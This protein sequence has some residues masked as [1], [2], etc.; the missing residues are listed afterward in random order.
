[1]KGLL[2]LAL[3]RATSHTNIWVTY[4]QQGSHRLFF[5]ALGQDGFGDLLCRQEVGRPEQKHEGPL[6]MPAL[7]VPFGLHQGSLAYT[8]TCM[9]TFRTCARTN[10]HTHM[11]T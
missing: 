11:Y 4:R 2:V 7:H 3:T 1:M 8:F 6:D 9:H 5:A 10:A